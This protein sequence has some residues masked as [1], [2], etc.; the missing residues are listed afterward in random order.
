MIKPLMLSEVRSNAPANL[1]GQLINDVL[2]SSVATDS[3]SINEGELF[4]ALSGENFDGNQ[5]VD[6]ALNKGAIGFV[7]N[8]SPTSN[9]APCWLVDD[10]QQALAAIAKYNRQLFTGLVI[11]ITGSAG[12]TTIKQIVGE[13]LAQQQKPLVT[14]GNFN[15]E[16]GVPLT[17]LDIN[18]QHDIAVIEMGAAKQGDIAYLCDMVQPDITLVN[19]A[20]AAHL[21]GFKSLAGVAKGK[22]EIYQSLSNNGV[23]VINKDEAYFDL[24]KDLAANAKQL[25]FSIDKQDADVYITNYVLHGDL[26]HQFTLHYKEQSVAVNLSLLGFHNVKNALAAAA[27]CLAAACELDVIAKGLSQVKSVAGRMLATQLSEDLCVVD[28]TYNANPGSVLAAAEFLATLPH[29]KTFILGDMAELGSDEENIHRETIEK[30]LSVDIDQLI[31]IGK[32]ADVFAQKKM[33]KSLVCLKSIEDFIEQFSIFDFMGTVLVKGSRSS[34]MENVV[35][36]LQSNY[37]SELI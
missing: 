2:F 37:S 15:N 11:G 16:I 6:T 20:K 5:F 4:V 28:D 9:D 26:S 35:T 36:A 14:K 24:W 22:G 10:T 25:S 23:A 12:K 7:A 8:R 3:R 21:E 17:L 32:F 34:K 30:L 29:S 33:S 27:V 19:N 31:Y 13:I 18:A 1:K